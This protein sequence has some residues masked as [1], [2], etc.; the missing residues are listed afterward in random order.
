MMNEVKMIKLKP[1]T[2][3]T[4]QKLKI[5]KRES[6]DE[7]INRLLLQSLAEEELELNTDTMEILDQRIKKMNE[8]KVSSF[9][10][11]LDKLEKKE[12]AKW[13]KEEENKIKPRR[14]KNATMES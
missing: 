12:V 11:I 7:V 14:L 3:Q 1:N 2:V 6:Y 10:N 13:E 4:L 8:G 9:Q 5:A